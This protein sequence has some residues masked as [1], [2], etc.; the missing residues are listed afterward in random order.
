MGSGES[1][2]SVWAH[3]LNYVKAVGHWEYDCATVSI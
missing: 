3:T 1:V 2:G